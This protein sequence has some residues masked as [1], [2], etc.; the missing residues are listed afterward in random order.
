MDKETLLDSIRKARTSHLRWRSYAQAL[1]S[2]L[3]VS[4]EQAPINHTDCKFGQWY[5]GPAKTEMGELEAYQA[6]DD[7]H[8]QLHAAY[9]RLHGFASEGRLDQAEQVM[10]EINDHCR[11]LLERLDILEAAVR[12]M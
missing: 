5:Y 8:A 10:G 1:A 2:G 9:R 6:I 7:P 12:E 11:I 4:E 3:E